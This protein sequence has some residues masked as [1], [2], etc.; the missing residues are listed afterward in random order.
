MEPA[1]FATSGNRHQTSAYARHESFALASAKV[2]VPTNDCRCVGRQ[3]VKGF[4]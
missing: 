4:I 1:G 2:K 3:V